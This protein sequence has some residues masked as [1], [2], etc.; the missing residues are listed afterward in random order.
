MLAC[1]MC[2]E[3]VF[4]SAP[5]RQTNGGRMHHSQRPATI[6]TLEQECI[7]NVRAKHIGKTKRGRMGQAYTEL[8]SKK[9]R[10]SLVEDTRMR[11]IVTAVK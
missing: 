7:C 8:P 3:D 5:Q 1:K 4:F 10:D 2:T 11:N 6:G 9:V